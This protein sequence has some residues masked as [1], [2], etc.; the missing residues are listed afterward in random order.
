MATLTISQIEHLARTG[1]LRKDIE[2]I[3]GRRLNAPEQK[4]FTSGK[5]IINAMTSTERV[6]K[7]RKKE[8]L[9]EM[10]AVGDP[11][12]RKRLERSPE[13]WLKYYM[14][15][16]FPFPFA[17]GHKEVIKNTVH[18]AKTGQGVATAQPRGEGKTTTLRG[19]CIYLVVVK[20]V[21]FPVLAG[22]KHSDAKSGFKSW[23]QMLC[24]SNEFAEDYPEYTAPFRYSTHATAL[25]NL[26]WAESAG[27]LAGV[28]VGASVDAEQKMIILPNSLGAIAAKSVQGDAKGLNAMMQDGSV[29]R[30][31]FIIFD[32]AQDPKRANKSEAVKETIDTIENVFMG[33]AGPQKRLVAAMACTIEADNDVSCYFLRKRDWKTTI[34]SR[35]SVWPDGSSGGTWDSE[36]DCQLRKMWDE[37][38]EIYVSEGQKEAAQ[39]FKKNREEMTGQMV[40]SWKHRFDKKVDVCDIDAAM[41]EWYSLGEDV[42]SRAQQNNPITRGVDV[43]AITPEIVMSRQLDRKP[44]ELPDWTQFVIAASDINPAYAITSGV[45]AFGRDHSSA[46]TWYGKYE[47][48]PLPISKNLS[49]SQYHNAVYEALIRH[50]R[51][52]AAN[53][54]SPKWWIID[55]GGAQSKPVKRLAENSNKLLGL[56][57]IVSYGRAGK[58]YTQPFNKKLKAG[59]EWFEG[60]HKRETWLIWNTDYWR[61]V[62]QRSFTSETGSI[63]SC[64]IFKGQHREFAEHICRKKLQAKG[65]VG[66]KMVWDWRVDTGKD[67]YADMLNMAFVGAA[68]AGGI[69]TGGL[70]MRKPTRRTISQ[71]QLKG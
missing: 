60:K 50:G 70:E 42:F 19:V 64:T 1:T 31:D 25:K 54:C 43:Y 16:A 57:V 20:V 55:A 24:D 48:A 2:A 41:R 39:F 40:T 67:D 5:P 23:L 18:A 69:G 11:K 49:E 59:E 8:R 34:V 45:V 68:Y 14:A 29:L 15:N 4:A 28:G 47:R 33:M 53:P 27:D 10:P 21:K 44:Y 32:D 65:I 26:T 30:P 56:N 7:F 13:K 38:R 58:A 71:S 63:G 62:A 66:R 51:E 37:W 9:I 36:K 52:I 12:R 3:I 46:L 17:A 6:E 61:E 22:W 35:V